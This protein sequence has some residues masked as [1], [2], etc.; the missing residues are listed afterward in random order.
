[1]RSLIVI[2]LIVLMLASAFL[3]YPVK[4]LDDDQVYESE[5]RKGADFV[6]SQFNETFGLVREF[7]SLNETYWLLSDNLLCS[8]ALEPYYPNMTNRINFEMDEWGYTKD[9]LHEVFFVNEIPIPDHRIKVIVL[10][11]HYNYWNDSL[12]NSSYIIKTEQRNGSAVFSDWD[13]Y[14]DRMIY[15]GLSCYW[16]ENPERANQYFNTVK[17]LWDGRGINDTATK[18]HGKYE[19]YK[20][21]LFYYFAKVMNKEYDFKNALLVQMFK[22]QNSTVGGFYTHYLADGDPDPDCLMNSETTALVLIA[23]NYDP[24]YK[25]PRDLPMAITYLL[26]IIV[27]ILALIVILKKI[28]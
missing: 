4:A 7:E 12:Y 21:A 28:I 5:L 13:N 22:M 25:N 8:Y 27:V 23:L 24:D 11:E 6:K 19:T 9:D 3:V 10:D 15:A 20:L 26:V 1:M 17:A 18:D 14:A 16:S 2:S